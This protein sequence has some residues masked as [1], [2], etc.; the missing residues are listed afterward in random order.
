M[1]PGSLYDVAG[2]RADP[3]DEAIAANAPYYGEKRRRA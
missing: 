2:V 3:T 1:L